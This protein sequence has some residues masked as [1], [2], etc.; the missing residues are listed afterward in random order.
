MTVT[1]PTHVAT[2][3]PRKY[4][5]RVLRDMLK[6]TFW[7]RFTSKP[8]GGGAVIRQTEL[9]N[10]PGETV[11]IQVTAPLTGTGVTELEQLEGNEENLTTSELTLTPTYI[12]HGVRLYRR[13][14]KKSMLDLREEARMR[15]AEWARDRLDSIRFEKWS[16]PAV[17]GYPAASH[18]VRYIGGGT[19]VDD[20]SVGDLVTLAEI[21]KS[22]Y[23]LRDNKGLPFKINGGEFYVLVVDP[24]VE[25]SIKVTDTAYAQAQREAGLRGTQNPLF[26]GAQAI[27]D[28]VVIHA[29]DRVVTGD[30]ATSVRYAK[31]LMFGREAFI[32]AFG[33]GQSWV[34][35]TFDYKNEWGVAYGFDYGCKRGFE[36]RSVQVV[37][38]APVQS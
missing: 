2:S 22:K 31:N 30:N 32:E 8:G 3:I 20:I 15:L 35:E 18:K 25:F 11:Y 28:G 37:S 26:T 27:W 29:A 23:I 17:A 19:G 12:R 34:E 5:M 10:K 36:F 1:T 6:D 16:D 4:A 33:G 21:S 24:W 13:A 38:A 7:D 14:E 9:E